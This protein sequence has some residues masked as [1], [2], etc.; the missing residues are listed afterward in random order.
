MTTVGYGDRFP[1]TDEG[2]LVGVL[3]MLG[4]IALLGVFTASIAA[5]FVRRFSAVEEIERTVQAEGD[6]TAQLLA[7]L[8]ARLER[9]ERLLQERR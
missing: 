8:A 1:T 9:V 6:S 7:D 3:L 2:R 5:W 4:G